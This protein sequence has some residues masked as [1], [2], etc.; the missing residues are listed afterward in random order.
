MLQDNKSVM[1]T[2][3]LSGCTPTTTPSTPPAPPKGSCLITAPAGAS[4]LAV[5]KSGVVWFDT[6]GCTTKTQADPTGTQVRWTLVSG[7]VPTGMTAPA[8]SG[9]TSGNIIGTPTVPGTY[10]FTLQVSDAVGQTDQESYT[11]VVG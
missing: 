11:V 6:T 10:R 7:A 5:N 4:N 9:L 8:A 2:V 3:T 1:L